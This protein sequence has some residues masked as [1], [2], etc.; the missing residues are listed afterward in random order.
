MHLP[1]KIP[2]F[3]YID[4]KSKSKFLKVSTVLRK[5]ENYGTKKSYA[6][7]V[8]IDAIPIIVSITSL[9][10]MQA[11]KLLFLFT[12]M[13]ALLRETVLNHVKK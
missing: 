6:V 11:S 3:M 8:F 1:D 9:T 13:I 12:W 5:Q 2:A 10:Q 7:S 4:G